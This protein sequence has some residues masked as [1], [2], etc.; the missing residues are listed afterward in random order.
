MQQ[1]TNQDLCCVLSPF[2]GLLTAPF[3]GSSLQ[4]GV[5][6]GGNSIKE[7]FCCAMTFSEHFT[8]RK[9]LRYAV[10]PVVMMIFTSIYSVIDGLFLSNF[11][12]KEA[13][14]AVNFVLPY[15]MLFSSVGFL[16]GTGGSALIAKT[17]GEGNHKKANEIFSALVWVS[18]LTGAV[19]AT[20][21]SLFLRPIAEWQGAS[22]ELLANSLLYG[23]IYLLGVPACV[24][25][26]EFQSLFATAG[27][28]KLGLIST[29]T[30]GVS[31]IVLDALFVAIFSWGIVGA[32]AATIL[33]QLIGGLF[34]LVYFGRKNSSL[35]HIVKCRPDW[36]ALGKIAT[37][38]SSEMINNLS[39]AVV[40][41]LYNM[42]LLKY[43]GDDGIAAYGVLMYVNFLFTAIF[44]GYVV[45]ISPIIS[46]HYGAKN[47]EELRS[48]LRKSLVII[49][50]ASLLMFT[51]SECFAVPISRIF[52]GYDAEL[53]QMT[54][55]GFFLFSFCFL[56]AGIAIFSSSF[57]T[58]LN[59][60]LISAFL[61]CSRVFLFQ[62]PVILTLPKFLKLDGV[63][64]SLVS[65]ELLT[66]I[67]G[68]ILIFTKR[69]K[70][71]Y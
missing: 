24:I 3:R 4:K 6:F 20:I 1:R 69:K 51:I 23:R 37:N 70:Y 68:L 14:A 7:E 62:V 65:A 35:L 28:T 12:G 43:A 47:H 59:N 48:L 15:L 45:G 8:Y 55:H 64:L 27:K 71:Q 66:A 33:S 31:N 52:V 49:F 39:I 10:S 41:L 22:G 25:Q 44:W 2:C 46:Y 53:L 13:F 18:A 67:L 34:P 58:S 38:G 36:R 42:Q 21:G 60:G 29:I 57:F 26:Y 56:F 9:L 11:V 63:W 16:F 54:T 19:F 30:S 32:A 50:S 61:S 17:L 40:S 5:F